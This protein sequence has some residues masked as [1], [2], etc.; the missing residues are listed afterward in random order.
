MTTLLDGTQFNVADP[1]KLQGDVLD[2]ITASD[3]PTPKSEVLTK[4][5]H[6]KKWRRIPSRNDDFEELL[7]ALGFDLERV[8][9]KGTRTLRRTNVTIS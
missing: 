4:L 1:V 3:E 6:E 7:E 8:Y 2:I 5:R 9:I